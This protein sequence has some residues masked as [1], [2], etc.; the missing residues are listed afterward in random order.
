[1]RSLDDDKP[2]EQQNP[3]APE[4]GTWVLGLTCFFPGRRHAV[5]IETHLRPPAPNYLQLLPA[6]TA[7]EDRA[8]TRHF[9]EGIGEERSA[10]SWNKSSSSL[11]IPT[12]RPCPVFRRP[13]SELQLT[14]RESGTGSAGQTECFIIPIQIFRSAVPQRH[15]RPVVPAYHTVIV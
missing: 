3:Q 13:S 2:Q 4:L 8:S 1:V 11:Q 10:T 6:I 15:F 7:V 14:C 9:R 12:D 5:G